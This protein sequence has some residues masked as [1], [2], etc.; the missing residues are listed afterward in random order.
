[1]SAKP[2]GNIRRHSCPRSSSI[3][4]ER[5]RSRAMRE[6]SSKRVYSLPPEGRHTMRSLI[7]LALRR[8]KLVIF[9][10]I[11]ALAV[12]APFASRLAGVLRGTTDAVPGS[13][14]ELASR[15]L[16]HAFGKGSAFV[17]PAVLTSPGIPTT[18][19][20]FAAAAV[21]LERV[22]DSAG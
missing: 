15:D 17:F 1:I 6:R 19:P 11:A 7:Q 14:S 18:D 12:A 20:R 4:L 3:G 2:G 9:A 16:N 22:L 8:P 21:E 5:G 10:W 13:P